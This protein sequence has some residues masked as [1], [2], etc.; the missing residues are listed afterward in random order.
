MEKNAKI[1]VAGHNGMVGSA[2]LRA[3]KKQGFNNLVTRS[4]KELDLRDQ[5][6]TQS[7]FETEKPEYVFLA[8]AKV[9]GIL[10]NAQKQGEFFHDNMLIELNAIEA[11]RKNGVKKFCFLGSSCIYPKLAEQPIKEE[12]LMTGHL[13]P[14]NFGYATAKIAGIKMCEA[15]H[16]QYGFKYVALMPCNLYGPGDNFDP[17]SSHVLPALL[18]KT[19]EAKETGEPEVIL[20][21]TGTPR[22]EFLFVDD[23]A[24]ACLF[25]ME[26][27][28]EQ[29][30]FNV[31]MGEDIEL[32]ELLQKIF[33]VVG[34]E[35]NIKHDLTKPDGTP[36]K[37]LDIGKIKALG[38]QPTI[39]LDEGIGLL[40]Q[41]FLENREETKQ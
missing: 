2:I 37:L 16:D 1:Y 36:R 32:K 23:V 11:A 20:W 10:A 3:L 24:A 7:F 4:S 38:W 13:E 25:L 19:V 17:E 35:G 29:G 34:Y 12:S 15:Y 18:R 5:N 6:A 30:L 22:R 41:W 14:T 28:I 9:G 26:S 27:G 40:Y 21:G 39:T 31:G 8:A 33:K